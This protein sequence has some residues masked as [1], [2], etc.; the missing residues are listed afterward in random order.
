MKLNKYIIGGLSAIVA[1]A[2]LSACNDEKA[3]LG[4]A[5]AVYIEMSSIATNPTLCAGDTIYLSA[6]VSNV[7]GKVIDT[8]IKWSVDDESVA[9]VVEIRTAKPAKKSSRA[10]EGEEGE[11]EGEDNGFNDGDED[12]L[13]PDPVAVD[14]VITYRTALIGMPEAQGKTTKLRATLENGDYAVTVVT[15]VSRGLKDALSPYVEVKRS[16]QREMNDTVWFAVTPYSILKECT[17]DFEF[18]TTDVYSIIDNPEEQEFK[19]PYET[20]IENIIMDEENSR[21]GAIFTAPRMCGKA[22]CIMTLTNREGATVSAKAP[23]NIFPAMSPGFE[24]DGHR[25]GY[26]PETP[27]NIKQKLINPT[28]DINSTHLVGVCIGVDKGLDIDV[29]NASAAEDNGFCYWEIE[30][31]AVVV[32][33]AFYDYKYD[34]NNDQEEIGMGYVTYLKVRSGTR[35]GLTTIRYVMPDQTLVCNLTV[36]DFK[37]SHPVER[38]YV[39]NGDISNPQE[40]T[41]ATFRLGEPATLD[42]HVDPAASFRY[43]GITVTSSDNSILEPIEHVEDDG[44]IYRFT[45]KKLGDVVLTMTS[46]DKTLQFPV[47]VIDRVVLINWEVGTIDKV[48]HGGTAEMTAN[49]RMA[50]GNPIDHDVTWI[51]SDPSIATVTTKPGTHNVGVVSG[52]NVGTVTV[53]AEYNGIQSPAQTVDV[54]P[55]EDLHAS[56]FELD[57]RMVGDNGDGTFYI[58]LGEEL[59]VFAI[60]PF[61][62][63]G[64]FDGT[65]DGSGAY[66]EWK[67]V[68]DDATYHL[69]V[70]DNGDGTVA[71]TGY[72]QVPTGG[73]VVF[74]GDLFMM[75]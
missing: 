70:V 25:P 75:Y 40:I 16:Y 15:I 56:E 21:I 9:K 36:E 17:P 68:Y 65:F 12:L 50:S 49:V 28:M 5:D 33:D 51:V 43:H 47:T 8:P 14:S 62:T 67:E 58:I 44:A 46:L 22:E 13:P 35:E 64:V 52:L 74:D 4:G 20:K 24:V 23:L 11:G 27:S 48:M 6:V 32:E 2:G 71:I 26:G 37:K 60:I 45:T 59:D 30:G 61:E 7:A 29:L 57:Y 73:K 69:E 63:D 53:V 72:I 19:H 42:I 10:E 38:V 41:S 54:L 66:V 1:L 34:T 18:V 39:T 55:V 3:T 31:S